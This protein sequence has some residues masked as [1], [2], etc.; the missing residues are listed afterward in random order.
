MGRSCTHS[1]RCLP[2]FWTHNLCTWQHEKDLL[3]VAKLRQQ[4]SWTKRSTYCHS[5]CTVIFVSF[6]TFI[7]GKKTC[8]KL[9]VIVLQVSAMTARLEDPLPLYRKKE[10]SPGDPRRLSTTI[11]KTSPP[12]TRELVE[13]H[14]SRNL[15]FFTTVLSF[16][17][18][19]QEIICRL[20]MSLYENKGLC[21]KRNV[22]VLMISNQCC[23]FS[24]AALW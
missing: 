23:S 14:V 18:V 5:A 1:L 9:N 6:H 8:M 11:A 3:H 2:L 13:Q 7:G 24:K 4:Q 22:I 21:L 10:L 12:P 20:L 17:S 19:S 16:H 15:W